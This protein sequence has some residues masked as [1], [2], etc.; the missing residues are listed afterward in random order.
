MATN[1]G[2]DQNP[3]DKTVRSAYLA[4]PIDLTRETGFQVEVDTV[5]QALTDAGCSVFSPATAWSSG[6]GQ[7]NGALQRVNEAA[8]LASEAAVFVLP[9]QPTVGVV[10]ELTLA[11]QQWTSGEGGS[12][13]RTNNYLEKI[14]VVVD[15]DT[16]SRSWSLARLLQQVQAGGGSVLV[17]DF[18]R[19]DL[20]EI[21]HLVGRFVRSRGFGVARVGL[22]P[23][24]FSESAED[25]TERREDTSTEDVMYLKFAHVSEDRDEDRDE[26]VRLPAQANSQ[27]AGLDLYV[28]QA[29]TIEPGQFVDVPC[30]LGVQLPERSWAFL[31]G[32][33]STFRKHG[34]LVVNGVIDEG[35]RGELF[36]GVVNLGDKPVHVEQGQ[37]LAQLIVVPR[38]A[39]FKPVLVQGLGEGERGSRGFGSSGV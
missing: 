29:V 24:R 12:W 21:Y 11:L 32:R 6:Y 31:T 19:A 14:L 35:Y 10:A 39:N 26:L 28:S 30:A 27:D 17:V 34:L 37:R 3:G 33:S 20:D 22:D 13:I 18:G 15:P 5:S 25:T 8:L 23:G 9:G 16:Y 36:A 2:S 7:P 38:Y 1:E 4:A